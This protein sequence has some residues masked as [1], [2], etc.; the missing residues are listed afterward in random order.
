M[1][2]LCLNLL[3]ATVA[4]ERVLDALLA[5]DNAGVFTSSPA[6]AHGFAHSELSTD[7]QVSG[8]SGATLVQ[9]LVAEDRL[10][11]LLA[12]LQSELTRTAVRYWVT[13]VIRQGEF[14]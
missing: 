9:V 2:D 14:Q 7:E 6:S 11:A 4:E 12:Q 3:C 8:R 10:D 13:P 5:N 1:A